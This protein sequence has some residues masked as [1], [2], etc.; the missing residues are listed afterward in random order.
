MEHPVIWEGTH[1][2]G[3]GQDLQTVQVA[4]DTLELG[5]IIIEELEVHIVHYAVAVY[6]AGRQVG[7]QELVLRLLRR[8][9]QVEIVF[10]II[11]V[12][13]LADHNHVEA[14]HCQILI[15]R[16]GND[17]LRADMEPTCVVIAFG[18]E[19]LHNEA[20]SHSHTEEFGVVVSLVGIQTLDGPILRR[21]HNSIAVHGIGLL[22]EC[23]GS[24][25]IV[26]LVG[27]FDTVDL[28]QNVGLE[29][30]LIVR[31]I[32]G[33]AVHRQ[34]IPTDLALGIGDDEEELL[35]AVHLAGIQQHGSRQGDVLVVIHRDLRVIDLVGRGGICAGH[36][37]NILR[38][39][40]G[41]IHLLDEN[42]AS[43][44]C[45]G[46]EGQVLGQS[47]HRSHIVDDLRCIPIL[48]MPVA[49]VVR[50]I[51]IP[52]GIRHNGHIHGIEI[53][54]L[55]PHDLILIQISI[56][57]VIRDPDLLEVCLVDQGDTDR[58][59]VLT[60]ILTHEV[61]KQEAVILILVREL[62][63]DLSGQRLQFIVEVDVVLILPVHHIG[64]LGCIHTTLI[65]L[66]GDEPAGHG[67][68]GGVMIGLE[69]IA[70]PT[71]TLQGIVVISLIQLSLP[72]LVR[73]GSSVI[74]II[75]GLS[76]V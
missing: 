60:A 9:G 27:L 52:V 16:A 53:V 8:V 21:F 73:I 5:R 75:E 18:L 32:A 64:T 40:P 61:D 3:L 12:A 35:T 48:H 50:F 17:L 63:G 10:H 54:I 4:V 74:G 19:D 31:I 20:L 76:V 57:T 26:L 30:H 44:R 67:Y 24:E 1:Q 22:V 13:L 70:F 66:H 6:I 25:V 72:I 42:G 43:R 36:S 47:I 68:F 62:Q 46:V 14:F 58:I 56:R 33:L 49:A 11:Q 59:S 28:T 71:S 65:E 69:V 55:T 39:R 15:L 2:V 23:H 7:S 34:D 45:L 29:L 51:M 41:R 38:V 37:L